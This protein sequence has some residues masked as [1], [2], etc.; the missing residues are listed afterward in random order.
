MVIVKVN[1]IK[2]RALLDTVA[3]SAYALETLVE[4]INIKRSRTEYR[5]IE[6]MIRTTTRNIKIYQVEVS[7]V[8]G[9][10]SI[11]LE[12]SK[13]DRLVFISLTN[14]NNQSLCMECN[15]LKDITVNNKDTKSLL[16]VHIVLGASEYARIKTKTPPRMGKPG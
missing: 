6:M 5:N 7:D 11:D 15:H 9:D 12:V 13:V 4:K 8:E 10:Y 14:P 3:G 1:G 2:S 16:P